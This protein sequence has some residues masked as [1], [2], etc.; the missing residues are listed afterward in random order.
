MVVPQPRSAKQV[1]NPSELASR[2]GASSKAG[3]GRAVGQ[4]SELLVARLLASVHAFR[5]TPRAARYRLE[6]LAAQ[7]AE[8]GS[9]GGIS[10]P[11]I[12]IKWY[13]PNSLWPSVNRTS[14]SRRYG[15]VPSAMMMASD[16]DGSN[17][18]ASRTRRSIFRAA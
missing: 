15:V 3:V 5:P 14:I 11:C 12:T 6:S 10:L 13:L 17:P 4:L 7:Q 18:F 1:L 8:S 2:S 9:Y 16:D